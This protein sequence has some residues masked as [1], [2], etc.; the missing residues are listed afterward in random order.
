MACAIAEE[1]RQDT[2]PTCPDP[3]VPMQLRDELQTAAEVAQEAGS[4]LDIQFCV[5][6]AFRHVGWAP[7]QI[8][9]NVALSD[10]ALDVAD[11]LLSLDGRVRLLIEV[12]KYGLA[13]DAK[14][15]VGRYCSLLR[16]TPQLALATDGVTWILYYFGSKCGLLELFAGQLPDDLSQIADTVAALAPGRIEAMDR[17]GT[18]TYLDTV[19]AAVSDLGEDA[20][21]RMLPHLARTVTGF[22]I[23]GEVPVGPARADAPAIA[24]SRVADGQEIDVR[25]MDSDA[26]LDLRFT[27]VDRA[28]FAGED[29]SP[30]W[31]GLVEAA[32]RTALRGGRSISDVQATVAANLRE[33]S[34]HKSGFRPIADTGISMQGMESRRAWRDALALAKHMGVALRVEFHWQNNPR[35]ERPGETGCLEWSPERSSPL[36]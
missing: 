9:Q 6:T 29:I 24:D 12:K 34:I 10:K 1:I 2:T 20:R 3:G 30:S 7:R 5:V 11:V 18:F 26:D 15:Q 31:A 13:R 4:E 23:P 32:V 33:G 36:R 17:D 14:A 8:R 22:L 16:P 28:V 21:H 27:S 19:D 35:A 25:R